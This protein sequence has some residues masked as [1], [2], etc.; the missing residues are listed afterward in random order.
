M[1]HA[2]VRL[3]GVLTLALAL[4]ASNVALASAHRGWD[5]ERGWSGRGGSGA[6]TPGHFG[7]MPL[8]TR[9]DTLVRVESTFDLPDQGIVVHRHERGTVT[10]PGVTSLTFTLATDEVVSVS[11]DT[12]TIVV[13]MTDDT[14]MRHFRRGF[15]TLTLGDI[16]AGD[17]V[18]VASV[19]QEDGTFLARRV[20]VL[21]TAQAATDGLLEAPADEQA[22]VTE[23]ATPEPLPTADA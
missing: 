4:V 10:A 9:L 15:E 5:G 13:G 19:R 23:A 20:I 8:R 17:E 11:A 7:S 18:V 22:P 16:T 3:A 21:P 2:R 1:S 6:L 12:D 14:G